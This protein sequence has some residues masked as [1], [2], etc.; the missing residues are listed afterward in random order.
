WLKMGEKVEHAPRIFCVNWFRLDQDGRFLWPGFGENMRVLEWMVGRVQG[1]A[2]ARETVLGWM[3]SYE[4]LDWTGL[5]DVTPAQFEALMQ[6][7]VDAWRGEVAAHADWFAKLADRLPKA[8]ADK[9][10]SL[11][12]ALSQ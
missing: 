8:L 3:P 7:D 2:K 4:D 11:S 6:L 5:D 10:D 12:A 9:R 1:K